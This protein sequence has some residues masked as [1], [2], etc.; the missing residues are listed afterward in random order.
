[1]GPEQPRQHH[2][3]HHVLLLALPGRALH[4]GR[5]LL[6]GLLVGPGGGDSCQVCPPNQPCPGNVSPHTVLTSRD[7]L[8]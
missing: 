3:R 2:V 8:S 4:R 7:H 5:Q 1:M 6:T